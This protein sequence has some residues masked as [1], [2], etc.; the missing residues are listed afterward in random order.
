MHIDIQVKFL[1]SA[2][3]PTISGYYLLIGNDI[4]VAH[5]RES[6]GS[7]KVLY[8]VNAINMIVSFMGVVLSPVFQKNCL[9]LIGVSMKTW[10]KV[11]APF[12]QNSDN[13]GKNGK[14]YE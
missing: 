11:L 13:S 7:T 5:S 4:H 9:V 1:T 3:I 12:P 2:N 10:R 14:F 6:V 8:F